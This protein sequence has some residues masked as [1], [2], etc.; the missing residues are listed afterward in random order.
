MK[1]VL[2]SDMHLSWEPSV[3]RK[4]ENF[5]EMQFNKLKF[6]FDYAKKHD[7]VICQAGDFFETPRSWYLLPK[8]IDFLKSYSTVTVFS[9]FGQHDMY[10]RLED[11]ATTN[12]GVLRKS[13]CLNI[14]NELP[15]VFP[16]SR[17]S[18]FG[19]SWEQRAV[20]IEGVAEGFNILVVHAPVA[21]KALW[22][23]HE[24]I[25]AE[26]FLDRNKDFDV[27]LC[28]DIHRKFCIEKKGRYILNTGPLV[29]RE[30]N[31]YNFKHKTC[32]FVLDVK[33]NKVD[34]VIIPHRRADDVLSREHIE[35][36]QEIDGM[37]DG[38][39]SSMK[40]EDLYEANLSEN[41]KKFIDENNVSEDVVSIISGVM[42]EEEV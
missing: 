1:F 32:F 19:C 15:Y 27:I 2:L 12:L 14:L 7:C 33:K 6:V 36:Q 26:E 11:T 23:G 24:Y 20:K 35:R 16:E 31:K 40:K 41:L 25:D 10:M 37:L 29:R 18:L 17:I 30:A 39:V 21:E 3:A 8:M 9:I 38:F 34:E 13:K 4:D 22:G 5:V 42:S 28:G